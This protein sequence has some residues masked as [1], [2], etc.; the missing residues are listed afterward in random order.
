MMFTLI[1]GAG[2][3]IG[4]ALAFECARKN[5]NVLLVA[6]PGPE[7]ESTVNEIRAA[8]RNIACYCLGIDLSRPESFC[9]V[10]KWV[11]ENNFHVNILIN[12]VGVGSKGDFEHT[13]TIFYERQLELNVH[14]ATMLTRLFLPDLKAHAPSH[15]MNTS[16]MGGFYMIPGKTVYIASKA[17]IYYFSRSLRLE[18]KQHHINVSVLCPGGTNSNANTIAINKELKG[19]AKRSI[20]LPE[21]VAAEAIDKM[22]KGKARIIPGFINK[23]SYHISRLVPEFIQQMIISNAFRHVK[24]HKY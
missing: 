18:L 11:K 1:T 8:Y 20:L 13:E 17:Y 22:M 2:A 3:G 10:Y 12:N 7:L 14:A 16:S 19:I 9:G 4:K 5:M 15:I 23:L 24:K 21:E 6:L